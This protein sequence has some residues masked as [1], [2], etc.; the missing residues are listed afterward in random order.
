MA[1]RLGVVHDICCALAYLH[2]KGIIYRDLKP[3]NVGFDVHGIV[4]IF[5]FG[6]AK[7]LDPKERVS[8]EDYTMTG[9]TGSL[10]YMAPEVTMSKP[11]GLR[12]DVYSFSIMMWEICALETPYGAMSVEQHH[13]FAIL[14]DV[15]PQLPTTWPSTLRN[16][17]KKTWSR[18][19]VVRPSM[20]TVKKLVR[21]EIAHLADGDEGV[22]EFFAEEKFRRTAHI[23]RASAQV[24]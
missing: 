11:Y 5:D 8:R 15:R 3:E 9:E 24:S 12:A 1:H 19:P 10:R 13:E 20:K 4:K 17:L 21:A 7:E 14:R 6:L 22:A 16:L 23:E 18:D 2:S